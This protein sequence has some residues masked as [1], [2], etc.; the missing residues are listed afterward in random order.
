[1][2]VYYDKNGR[3]RGYSMSGKENLF[4]NH[5]VIGFFVW[6]AIMLVLSP[7]LIT[8]AVMRSKLEPGLKLLCI[9]ALWGALI[10]VGVLAGNSAS[11]TSPDSNASSDAKLGATNT[12]SDIITWPTGTS[13]DTMCQNHQ[14]FQEYSFMGYAICND[15]TEHG[16]DNG[17]GG[18]NPVQGP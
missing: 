8:G 3:P 17:Q 18:H 13:T 9:A 6:A 5:S 15:G 2:R 10:L 11:S 4:W 7:F 1:V 14:G 16:Y 12:S